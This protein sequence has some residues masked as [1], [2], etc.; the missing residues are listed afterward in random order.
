MSDITKENINVQ[1][2]FE[3]FVAKNLDEKPPVSQTK[4]TNKSDVIAKARRQER[5]KEDGKKS[6]SKTNK[7]SQTNDLKSTVDAKATQDLKATSD[8]KSTADLK[9]TADG[10]ATA[11][12][13]NSGAPEIYNNTSQIKYPFTISKEE[14][15][16]EEGIKKLRSRTQLFS[17][18]TASKD[19]EDVSKYVSW[20]TLDWGMYR[21][22]YDMY[23]ATGFIKSFMG[24]I[25]SYQYVTYEDLEL[26]KDY[27]EIRKG[28]INS[29]KE[30]INSNF[31]PDFRE[32]AKLIMSGDFDS[33]EWHKL[34]NELNKNSINEKNKGLFKLFKSAVTKKY[35]EQRN[36][37]NLV[38][39]IKL[40]RKEYKRVKE[41]GL[42]ESVKR[43]IL[44][45][46]KFEDIKPFG[47]LRS[48]LAQKPYSLAAINSALSSM[49]GQEERF[50]QEIEPYL[51]SKINDDGENIIVTMNSEKIPK[52]VV[53]SKRGM[54]SFKDFIDYE[55]EITAVSY[56]EN[57]STGSEVQGDAVDVEVYIEPCIEMLASH[58]KLYG[59]PVNFKEEG[60]YL[61]FDINKK[62]NDIISYDDDIDS[63]FRTKEVYRVFMSRK[64]K[65]NFSKEEIDYTR[66]MLKSIR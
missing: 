49:K 64:D 42:R 46:D 62:D 15:K 20:K 59:K 2:P 5:E 18:L 63:T 23:G 61:I 22:Y 51:E 26:F 11:V 54:Q 50:L 1:D 47:D 38:F 9:A 39:Y 36:N 17:D 28:L 56:Y 24:W 29:R 40:F 16:T 60:D 14:L 6:S 43:F 31:E 7:A 8:L 13:S 66:N 45:E 30:T 41:L 58:L 52:V 21:D 12:S 27:A 34:K 57:E 3:D 65:D 48:A 10:K 32:T 4:K 35:P 44:K 37:K 19:E 33:I 53:T 55:I 25:S